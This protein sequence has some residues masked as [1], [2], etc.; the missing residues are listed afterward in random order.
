MKRNYLLLIIMMLF[1]MV[2]WA[3]NH[4]YAVFDE[5]TG[6]LTFVYGEK[7]SGDH[8]YLTDHTPIDRDGLS[9]WLKDGWLAYKNELKKV[10]FEPSA[11]HVFWMHSIAKY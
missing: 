8:V 3:E 11:G 9:E 2:G 6:V 10:V 1:P 4:E 5:S 7:P